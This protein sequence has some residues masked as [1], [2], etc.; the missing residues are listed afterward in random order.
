MA[1]AIVIGVRVDSVT[2]VKQ[3]HLKFDDGSFG[4]A[5][6]DDMQDALNRVASNNVGAFLRV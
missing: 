4:I 3:Y 2:E 1:A 5:L 6:S